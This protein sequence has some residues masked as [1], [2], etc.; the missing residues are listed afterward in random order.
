MMCLPES[1]AISVQQTPVKSKRTEIS[2]VAKMSV[3][4]VSQASH[5]AEYDDTSVLLE[6][7]PQEFGYDQGLS[8]QK[9]D[10][11]DYMKKTKND[12]EFKR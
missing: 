5:E 9:K 6:D 7:L 4:M 10:G 2:S 8:F 3:R 11:Y 12:I 1:S